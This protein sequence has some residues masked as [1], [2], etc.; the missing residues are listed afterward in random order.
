MVGVGTLV[1]AALVVLLFG[2]WLRELPSAGWDAR[3]GSGVLWTGLGLNGLADE[4]FS[5]ELASMAE[6]AGLLL[7]VGGAFVLLVGPFG[8]EVEA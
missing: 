1:V 7:L 8:E 2:V 6:S 3:V 5:R 4:L